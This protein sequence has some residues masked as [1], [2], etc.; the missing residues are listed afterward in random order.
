M[1][2]QRVVNNEYLLPY[3]NRAA[4]YGLIVWCLTA[5]TGPLA[6]VLVITG[7]AVA[8]LRC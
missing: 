6:P 8:R 2:V 4:V 7:A 3:A 1:E 5:E